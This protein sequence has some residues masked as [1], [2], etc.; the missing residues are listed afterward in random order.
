MSATPPLSAE[1]TL[2][3]RYQTTVPAFVRQSLGLEKC[4]RIRYSLSPDNQVV[5]MSCE[6][7]L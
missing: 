7:Q 4:D 6:I 5:S 1:S 2:T 3:A